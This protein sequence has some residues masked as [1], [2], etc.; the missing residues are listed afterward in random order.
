MAWYNKFMKTIGNFFKGVFALILLLIVLLLKIP[1]F[2]LYPSRVYGRKNLKVK[3]SG[4][5]VA[6]NHF[7]NFDVV[8][9]TVKLFPNSFSRRYL[10]KR[11]L[12]KNKFLNFVLIAFGAI[13]ITL[14]TADK[15]A[16]REVNSALSSKKRV[17]IFPEGTRNKLG[18][19][20]CFKLNQVW[21]ILQRKTMFQ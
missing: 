13:F 20:E 4:S 8:F 18:E 15:K 19:T 5:V 3:G 11:E 12:S 9:L 21:F 17:V 1:F 7:S 16:F 10:A 14:G 2:I 6:C